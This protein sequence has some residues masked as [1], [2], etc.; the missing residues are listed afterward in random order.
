MIGPERERERI[1]LQAGTHELEC[2]QI[3]SQ[4]VVVVI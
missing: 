4:F 1:V 3:E 2:L